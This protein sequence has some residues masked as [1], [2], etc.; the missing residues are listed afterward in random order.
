MLDIGNL[1][2]ERDYVKIRAIIHSMKPTVMVMGV[3]TG[4]EIIKQI[5]QLNLAALDESLFSELVLKLGKV[6]QDVNEQ[7]RSI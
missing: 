3:I 5:E 2:V 4:S 1:V 7:L 6:L